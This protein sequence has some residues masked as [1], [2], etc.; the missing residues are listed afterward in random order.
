MTVSIVKKAIKKVVTSSVVTLVLINEALAIQPTLN[1][2][3]P[4]NYISPELIEIFE[5]KSHSELNI[6][7][8]AS[9]TANASSV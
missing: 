5:E 3:A 6:T 9:Q 7:P 2:L 8:N 1:L 4:D